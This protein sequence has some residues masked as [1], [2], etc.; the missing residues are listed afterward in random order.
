MKTKDKL[1]RELIKGQSLIKLRNVILF[2][3]G[4]VI[5]TGIVCFFILDRTVFWGVVFGEAIS[6]L[7]FVTTLISYYY[8]YM[9]KSRE[10]SRRSIL[11]FILGIFFGKIIF[12][13]IVFYVLTKFDFL[14][15]LSLI[16]SF[17]LLFTVF[18][19]LVI[20]LTYKKILFR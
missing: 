10:A 7:L 17:L 14:S 12:V 18:L 2:S 20:F 11:R 5:V 4:P 8:C 15:L 13:G 3:L 1:G 19:N 6:F 9:L 16:V